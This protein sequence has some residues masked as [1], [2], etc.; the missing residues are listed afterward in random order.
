MKKIGTTALAVLTAISI[1]T[2]SVGCK[3]EKKPEPAKKAPADGGAGGGE[4]KPEGGH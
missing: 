3:S 1:T 2:L 4:K